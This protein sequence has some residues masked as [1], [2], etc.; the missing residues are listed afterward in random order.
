M[1]DYLYTINVKDIELKNISLRD[2]SVLRQYFRNEQLKANN[3]GDSSR[4][5]FHSDSL[6]INENPRR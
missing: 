1:H 6:Q 2:F 4:S 5:S 3:R